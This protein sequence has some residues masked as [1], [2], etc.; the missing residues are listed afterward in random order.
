[1]ISAPGK[2]I[3]LLIP[4]DFKYSHLLRSGKLKKT[5]YISALI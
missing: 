4:E 1:M 2:E 5:G 3:Y